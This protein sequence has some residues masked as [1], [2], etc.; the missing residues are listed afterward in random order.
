MQL[1]E[2]KQRIA[3][4]GVVGAGG[5]GFPSAVKLAEGADTLIINAAECEPLLYTDFMILR[6]QLPRM[7]SGAETV[8]EAA[9]IRRGVLA[10]RED[11]M[12]VLG[13]TDGQ[14]ISAHIT[15]HALPNV[16]PVGDEIILVYEIMHRVVAPGALPI[17]VGAIVYNVETLLNI[18]YAVKDG[19]PVTQKWLTVGGQVREPMVVC[20]PIGMR[21]RE[22]L[23]TLNI[24]VPEDSVAVDGGPAMGNIIDV[25]QAVIKKT[26]KG[27]TIYPRTIP[28]MASKLNENR[29]VNVHAASNCCQCTRCTDL[30]PRA[31]IGYPLEPHKIVRTSL[32][33]VEEMPELFTGAT[34]CSN[35]G[36]CELVACCQNI[37]PRRVYAQ[38][39]GILA[40]NKLR[41]NGP[42]NEVD[43]DRAYRMV[44]HSRFVRMI[45][46]EAY[47][48]PAE[49]RTVAF[50]P[51]EI[52]L[53]TRQHVGAPAKAVVQ[54]GDVVEAGTLIAA[55]EGAISANIH[56]P[57]R[58]RVTAV[59]ESTVVLIP[60]QA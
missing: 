46:V 42:A 2:L 38:V 11:N 28:A 60:Q 43:P 31:L 23:E 8:I 4:A 55:A 56:A 19:T 9:G 59:S 49:L 18:D 13:L 15:V 17:S 37:S 29:V 5:A 58:A 52:R 16:Y 1:N 47:E 3:Q 32:S 30:C 41:Y 33:I 21:V 26:T 51:K 40:R 25:N 44:P 10:V 53:P 20:A 45:G 34:T 14:K 35:C 22:L 36:L 7:L 50:A 6:T 39:K 57:L 54:V 27:I 24:S 12:R 48:Q